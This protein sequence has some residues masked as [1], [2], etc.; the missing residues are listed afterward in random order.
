MV[1][2]LAVCLEIYHEGGECLNNGMLPTTV[3]DDRCHLLR[4]VDGCEVE[5]SVASVGALV[6][7]AGVLQQPLQQS[8]VIVLG[9]EDNDNIETIGHSRAGGAWNNGNRDP[10]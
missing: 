6:H 4:L 1:P 7:V 9:S 2:D 5:G 8:L 3:L 10:K